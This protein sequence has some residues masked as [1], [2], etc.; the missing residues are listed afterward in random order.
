MLF[1]GEFF[2]IAMVMRLH[3]V[4]LYSAAHARVAYR[5]FFLGEGISRMTYFVRVCICAAAMR[6]L[7]NNYFLEVQ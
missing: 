1:I 6:I 7:V 5:I 3:P 4:L 2:K